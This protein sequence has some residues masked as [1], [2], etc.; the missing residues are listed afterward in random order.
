MAKIEKLEMLQRLNQL[1]Q[2]VI[3]KREISVI[4]HDNIDVDAVFSGVL[5]TKLLRFLGIDAKFVILQAIKEDDTYEIVSKFSDINMYSYVESENAERNLFLVD[6]YETIHS[7]KVAGCIDHHPTEK[8][9]TYEFSYVRNCSASAYMIYELM[10]VANYPLNKAEAKMI[11]ISMLVDTTSFRSSKTIPEEVIVAKKLANSFELDYEF[12]E[13]YCLCLTPIGN[14]SIEQIVTNGQKK[15]NYNG[16]NVRSAYLQLYGTPEDSAVNEWITFL[17]DM[18]DGEES[19][20]EMI[21]FII[22][23]AYSNVTHEYRI[24]RHYTKKVTHEGVLSRG[25]DIMPAIERMYSDENNQ[26]MKVKSIIQALSKKGYTISMMESCTGGSLSGTITNIPGISEVFNGAHTAYC[27]KA[28]IKLGVPKEIIDIF[29][30]YSKRTAEEMAKAVNLFEES[31]VGIGVTGQFDRADP[32]NPGAMV[33]KAWYTISSPEKE[34]SA[35]IT[36]YMD[37]YARIQKKN[38]IINE[39]IEDLYRWYK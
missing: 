17:H 24:T 23:D 7:G 29:G 36:L 2:C 38:V 8:E 18:I 4:G 25:K 32:M 35:V 27:N 33:D 13:R 1:K 9:N 39:I 6:H 20:P 19:S 16:H 37:G 12:L 30:V 14:M 22:F 3:G 10:I 21:V 5:L 34:V 28:K 31:Q 11:I 15:Y 26:E